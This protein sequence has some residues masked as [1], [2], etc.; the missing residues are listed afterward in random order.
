MPPV[1]NTLISRRAWSVELA[2]LAA[3]LT[4][5]VL[6]SPA[7]SV[8]L[9]PMLTADALALGL[10]N[11]SVGGWLAVQTP[12]ILGQRVGYPVEFSSPPAEE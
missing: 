5:L 9:G 12:A 6:P 8:W 3:V 1:L 11:V 10:Y 2:L 7:K 4:T